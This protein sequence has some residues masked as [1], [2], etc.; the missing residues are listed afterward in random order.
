MKVFFQFQFRN[1]PSEFT[2]ISV[3]KLLIFLWVKINA[4][5]SSLQNKKN[6]ITLETERKE[7]AKGRWEE[8]D[9]N[10]PKGAVTGT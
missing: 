4:I 7:R 6:I 10:V 8:S 1:L 3:T 5:D 9:R 2:S